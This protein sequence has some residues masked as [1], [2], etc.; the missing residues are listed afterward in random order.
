[1]SLP[2]T[3]DGMSFKLKPY[4]HQIDAV[5]RSDTQKDMALLWE[6][7]TGKTGGMIN[8]LR[9]IFNNKRRMMRT[10]IVTPLVTVHNWK[11]EFGIHS[12]IAETDVVAVVSKGKKERIIHL[13][14]S[15]SKGGV[16]SIPKIVIINYDALRTKEIFD[17]LYEWRPEIL[18]CDESHYLKNPSAAISKIMV[19]FAD[20]A[21]RRFIM[22]GSPILNNV[23]DIYW[24][25]RI[26][27][28]GETFGKSLQVFMSK[29]TIDKNAGFRGKQGYFPLYV[30]NPATYSELNKLIYKKAT[31]ILKSECLDLPPLI[32]KYEY[33]ELSEQQLKHY[34]EMKRDFITFVEGANTKDAMTANIAAVKALR[35]MQ[36]ASGYL[37][38]DNGEF[39]IGDNPKIERTGEL[40]AD[41]VPNNKVIIWCCFKNNYIVL[42]ELCKK[43]KIPYVLLTGEQSLDQKN[44]SVQ[45]FQK[46]PN[47]RVIIANRRAGGIGINLTAASYSIVFSRNFSLGEELQSESR[48]HRGGSEIH[49][50]IVKIELCA[51]DTIEEAVI[52]ALN[53]KQDVSKKIID[54]VKQDKL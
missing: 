43:M 36:I 22:T 47:V 7:G 46:D 20:A 10:L 34:K 15:L 40:L 9:R 53:N 28:G 2:V 37:S 24:Q 33:V 27:D 38:T 31:R 49:E 14:G 35:L 13:T 42:S 39:P 48:N 51:K 44:A 12:N 23:K 8:I 30:P 11:N 26:L 52:E 6:M 19:K 45:A 4:N 29:F 5:L 16:L 21:Q 17:I 25:Y 50:Q 32:T 41:L 3:I 18:V 1:M 54:L